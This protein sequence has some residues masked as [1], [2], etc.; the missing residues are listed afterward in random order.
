MYRNRTYCVYFNRA[1]AELNDNMVV[2]NNWSDFCSMLDKQKVVQRCFSAIDS[3]SY[4]LDTLLCRRNVYLMI[5]VERSCIAN[6][7]TL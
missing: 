6:C 7:L 4:V 5:F 2:V 1:E 3:W